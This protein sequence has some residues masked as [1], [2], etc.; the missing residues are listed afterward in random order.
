MVYNNTVAEF[1]MVSGV[2]EYAQMAKKAL[3]VEDS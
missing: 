2:E 1:A 3:E